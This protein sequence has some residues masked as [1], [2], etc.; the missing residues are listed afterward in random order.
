MTSIN[1]ISLPVKFSVK[2]GPVG[3]IKDVSDAIKSINII[4]L[5]IVVEASCVVAMVVKD[6]FVEIRL[7]CSPFSAFKNSV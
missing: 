7:I 4:W 6:K 1:F 3:T 2:L 5:A